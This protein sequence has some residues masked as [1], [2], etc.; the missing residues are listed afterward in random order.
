M[1]HVVATPSG[2]LRRLVPD[3]LDLIQTFPKGWTDCGMSGSQRGF[4]MGNALVVDV[5]HAIGAE[6]SKR[7]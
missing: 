2:R 4:C 7:V 6:I 1:K 3:E 5:V